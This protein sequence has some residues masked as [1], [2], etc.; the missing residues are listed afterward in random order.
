[1]SGNKPEKA[2][3][4]SSGA[5]KTMPTVKGSYQSRYT[6][7]DNASRGK[8]EPVKPTYPSRYK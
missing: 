1:M 2:K 8:V 6:S 5:S 3:K 4:Q 7:V